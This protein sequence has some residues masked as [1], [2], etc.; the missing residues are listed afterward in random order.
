MSGKLHATG[1]QGGVVF[2]RDEDLYWKAK[3]FADRGKPFNTEFSTNVRLGLNLNGNDLAAA[4]GRV[5]LKKLPQIVEG[6]RQF[7]RALVKE[8]A[9]LK[10]ISPGWMPAESESS[11]W[12]VRMHI[13]CDKLAVDKAAFVSALSAE[14]IPCSE[15]YRAMPSES[16]WFR[17]HITYGQSGY[18]WSAP[19]Y[20]GDKN[21]IFECPNCVESVETHFSL[22]INE[23]FGQQE[24]ADFAE[25]LRKV[26]NAYLK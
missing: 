18:P 19:E 3:R 24:V 14:G 10:S 15:S 8:I 26:E 21:K 25:A 13:D 9:D 12:F 16:K 20:K 5:Q 6:R 1:A 11:Y 17:E 23:N 22:H 4:I 7:M 2:T